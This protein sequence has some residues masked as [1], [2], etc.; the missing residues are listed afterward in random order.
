M[1]VWAR[2]RF[3]CPTTGPTGLPANHDGSPC[4]PNIMLGPSISTLDV[5]G[6][7]N[8]VGRPEPTSPRAPQRPEPLPARS[9]CAARRSGRRTARA[10]VRLLLL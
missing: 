4:E 8:D 10:R 1:C 6:A 7:K 5:L 9:P 3:S 2:R